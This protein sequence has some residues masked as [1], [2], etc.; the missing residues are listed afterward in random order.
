M[1]GTISNFFK[2]NTTSII[3]TT[4]A[5]LFLS[6]LFLS[7]KK[8]RPPVLERNKGKYVKYKLIEKQNL[9]KGTN[10]VKLLRFAL[11]HEDDVLGLPVGQHLSLR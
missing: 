3:L 8:K 11:D 4:F 2:E 10:A 7:R 1:F 6:R 5:M 9:T